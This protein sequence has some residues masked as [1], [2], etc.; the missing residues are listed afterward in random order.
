M[1]HI[2]Q[3]GLIEIEDLDKLRTL[4]LVSTEKEGVYYMHKISLMQDGKE[5]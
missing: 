5:V 1:C 2:C 4:S 3:K